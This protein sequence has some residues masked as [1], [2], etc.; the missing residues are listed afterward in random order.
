MK[1]V[2]LTSS[3]SVK[4]S[5]SS[6]ATP[7]A[8]T[9]TDCR[10]DS[11]ENSCYFPRCRKDANCDCEM[12]LASINLTLDLMPS[13][14]LTKLSASKPSPRS[15]VSFNPS[16]PTSSTPKI[17]L[18]P[19][20]NSTERVS[21]REKPRRKKKELG[22]GYAMTRLVLALSLIFA[23]EM[24]F[25]GLI[26]WALNPELSL[27]TVRNVGEKSWVL[28]GVSEKLE[29]LQRE[30]EGL[31]NGEVSNCSSN[32]SSWKVHQGGLLLTSSC[33]LYK[34][35]AEEV[36][37]WGWPLQTAGLLTAE[38]SSLSLTILSGRITEWSSGKISY[39]TREANESWIHQK[40]SASPV[41]LDPNTWI[42]QYRQASVVENSGIFSAIFEFLKFRLAKEVERMKQE[43]WLLLASGDRYS[44]FRG[45]SFK[46]P[47]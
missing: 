2:V 47:T 36:R 40:W 44:D 22:F 1:T 17:T 20:I 35:A 39:S 8:G 26:F 14:T 29:F 38:L 45:K 6:T 28:K 23:A 4:S 33:T 34:T 15:P 25:S 21:L 31:T 42:L 13:S 46:N 16:T 32:D 30:L 37:V 5:A 7:V 24:G 12:C 27:E 3:S 18:S 10:S 11:R 9:T 41:Q 43:F 19:Q